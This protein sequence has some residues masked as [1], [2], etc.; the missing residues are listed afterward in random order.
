MLTLYYYRA[1]FTAHFDHFG[2]V[3]LFGFVFVNLQQLHAWLGVLLG[4]VMIQVKLL[5]FFFEIKLEN[6]NGKE[7]SSK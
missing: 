4:N 6:R 3:F 1:I 5:Q 2:F 7:L